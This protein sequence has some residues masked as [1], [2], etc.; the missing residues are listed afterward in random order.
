M[1]EITI[2]ASFKCSKNGG[3]VNVDYATKQITMANDAFLQKVQ[4][5]GT[6]TEVIGLD[7]VASPGYFYFKNLDPVGTVNAINIG[8]VT[9]GE[10][11]LVPSRQT[12][13][14]AKTD[15]AAAN[16]LIAACEV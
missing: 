15:N 11:A 2:G 5:I 13:I 4:N 8:L 7:D 10:F 9:P 6:T 16:L 14:Y 1:N 3:T 12:V